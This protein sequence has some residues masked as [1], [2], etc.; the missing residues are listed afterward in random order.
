MKTSIACRNF[1]QNEMSI[2]ILC[3]FDERNMEVF[4]CFYLRCFYL[5]S[6]H[7]FFFLHDHPNNNT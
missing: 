6:R 3:L 5:E 7:Y 2:K 1:N 4:G